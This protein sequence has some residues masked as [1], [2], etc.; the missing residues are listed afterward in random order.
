MLIGSLWIVSEAVQRLQEEEGSLNFYSVRVR[1]HDIEIAV[2]I[3][4]TTKGHE[5]C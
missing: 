4:T 3:L 5:V 1:F 2:G